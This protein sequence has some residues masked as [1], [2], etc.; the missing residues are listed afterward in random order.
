MVRE[1]IALTTA[2]EIMAVNNQVLALSFVAIAAPTQRAEKMKYRL[3][4]TMLSDG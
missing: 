4:K 3:A 2:P 1:K